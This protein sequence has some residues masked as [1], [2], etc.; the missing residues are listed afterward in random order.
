MRRLAGLRLVLAQLSDAMHPYS[1]EGWMT[2]PH[3]ELHD[4]SPVEWLAMGCPVEPVV[5]LAESEARS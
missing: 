3:E 5:W 2:L 1:V 4:R